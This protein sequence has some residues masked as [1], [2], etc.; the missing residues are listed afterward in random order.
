MSILNL[1]RT[2]ASAGLA[3][4]AATLLSG[5]TVAFSPIASAATLVNPTAPS[6]TDSCGSTSDTYTIPVTTGV[7]YYD[8]GVKVNAGI[9]KVDPSSPFVQIFAVAQPGYVLSQSASWSHLFNTGS[10]DSDTGCVAKTTAAPTNSIPALPTATG[11]TSAPSPSSTMKTLPHTG[12]EADS[13][14][15]A[16]GVTGLGA[17][18]LGGA[19]I[20]VGR[21]KNNGRHSVGAVDDQPAGKD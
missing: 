12:F 9:R 16:A 2:G 15:A 10:K 14:M 4:T 19:A 21:R 8:A 17:L 1:N 13:Y 18:A 7:D 20:G 5:A 3:L 6:F 11:T